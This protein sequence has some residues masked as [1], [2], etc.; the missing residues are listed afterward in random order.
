MRAAGQG[1]WLAAVEA[2]PALA[3]LRDDAW[4]NVVRV[5]RQLALHADWRTCT[6]RP[7]WDR[8]A[9]LAGVS[10]RTVARIVR[11]LHHAG[12]L[13][14]V[15]GG[16]SPGTVPMALDDGQ[17]WAAV[18]VLAV[19]HELRVAGDRELDDP[20]P[21]P[22]RSSSWAGR[23]GGWLRRPQL[24]AAAASGDRTGTPSR[25]PKGTLRTPPRAHEIR[26]LGPHE[27]IAAGPLWPGMRG[28]ASKADRLLAAAEARR[29]SPVLRRISTA[30]VAALLR[31]WMLAG[32][33]VVDVLTALD[34]RPDGTS[35]PHNL[36]IDDVRHVPGWVRY[37][38]AAWRTTGDAA[39]P[40]LPSPS[41]RAAAEHRHAQA[42]NRARAEREA[43]ARVQAADPQRH[44]AFQ[45]A[46]EALRRRARPAVLDAALARVREVR[47][48]RH[49]T[50]DGEDL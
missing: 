10:R 12:L 24:A 20:S 41:Q 27:L 17:A 4:A 40:P 13:G 15:A 45:A 30:Y 39:S 47:D 32:W 14:T 31:E 8:L 7:T 26:D 43:A 1:A 16:R 25:S 50:M 33:T 49:D 46:K 36:V 18:Y 5:G 9:E 19:P 3:Q 42:R 22:D 35:W 29:R 6:T 11:L 37:R 38:L 44:T 23:A 21:V 48:V 34:T 28:A 2:S